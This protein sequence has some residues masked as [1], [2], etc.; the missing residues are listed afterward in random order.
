[1]LIGLIFLG[2]L[3]PVAGGLA[4]AST[5]LAAVVLMRRRD[6][7]DWWA[8]DRAHALGGRIRYLKS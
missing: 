1:V 3:A 7:T 5:V 4:G 2:P 8:L 6:R